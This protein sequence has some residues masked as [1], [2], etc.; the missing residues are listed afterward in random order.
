VPYNAR[1]ESAPANVTRAR[2]RHPWLFALPGARLP[3][4]VRC[5]DETY[6]LV[7]TF[8]HDFFAATGVYRGPGGLVVLKIGRTQAVFSIPFEWSG[9]FLAAREIR[10]YRA[11][12]DLPGVPRFVGTVGTTGF[13]HDFI[14]G[15]PLGR[16]DEV[17]DEFFP[18]LQ[19]LLDALH[20]RHMAYV[21]L[22]KRQNILVGDDGRPYLI[23][24][25]ISLHLPPNGWRA[26]APVQ[27]LLRRFQHADRYHLLKHKRRLRPDQ[28]TPEEAAILER[29]SIWIR[30]H[31]WLARPLTNLRRRTLR[32][33]QPDT[34]DVAGASAK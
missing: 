7:E 15:R 29:L 2:L 4:T 33:L 16:R 19:Q 3:Q 17:S 32:R 26:W 8:K 25:Q 20:A 6:H 11:A 31:R 22:N 34:R 9:R 23:D 28:L 30:L 12:H 5:N 13:L 27:W 21:D 24:F 14:P 18:E 10:H 1:V